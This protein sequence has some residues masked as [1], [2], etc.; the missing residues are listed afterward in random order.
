MNDPVHDSLPPLLPSGTRQHKQRPRQRFTTDMRLKLPEEFRRLFDH[1]F[2]EGDRHLLIFAAENNSGQTRVGLSVSRKHG[3][4]VLRNRR[5]RLL[6]EAFRLI[7]RK[8][9]VGF[10]LVLI[11]R[12]QTLSTLGDY[13]Q[14]LVRLSERLAKKTAAAALQSRTNA[15]TS[16]TTSDQSSESSSS[17]DS[18]E[19]SN[20]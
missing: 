8:L 15:A 12:L 3:N 1:G 9:P 6:R 19:G 2:R 13:Q 18:G 11:P 7:H 16:F 17:C 10:D 4:A 5:K 14:S 20:R